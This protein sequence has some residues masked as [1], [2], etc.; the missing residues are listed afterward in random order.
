MLPSFFYFRP[1]TRQHFPPWAVVRG[2]CTDDGPDPGFALESGHWAS[3]HLV[4]HQQ[5]QRVW[6][7]KHDPV[8]VQKEPNGHFIE[9]SLCKVFPRGWDLWT[10]YGK[11]VLCSCGGAGLQGLPANLEATVFATLIATS[12]IGFSSPLS[13]ILISWLLKDA[14]GISRIW[15]VLLMLIIDIGRAK[16]LVMMLFRKDLPDF[17][18]GCTET[19]SCCTCTCYIRGVK[20][21]W[22]ERRFLHRITPVSGPSAPFYNKLIIAGFR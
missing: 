5:K 12:N 22:A 7:E 15:H 3:R 9:P 4:T 14:Q 20:C 13:L 6:N 19:M 10:D 21:M 16:E 11:D 17:A 2:P 18:P 1:C 8:D